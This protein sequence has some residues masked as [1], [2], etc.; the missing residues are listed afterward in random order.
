MRRRLVRRGLWSLRIPDAGR[1]PGGAA[2]GGRRRGD[3][4]GDHAQPA[5]HRRFPQEGGGGVDVSAAV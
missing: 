1:P 3:L 2:P 4:A 5:G